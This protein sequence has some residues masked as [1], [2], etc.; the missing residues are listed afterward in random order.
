MID[1]VCLFGYNKYVTLL[2]S[3]GVSSVRPVCPALLFRWSGASVPP[4]PVAPPVAA[5]LSLLL[6]FLWPTMAPNQ[7]VMSVG[8]RSRPLPQRGTT[9]PMPT[10]SD[11]THR[12]VQGIDINCTV[13]HPGLLWGQVMSQSFSLFKGYKES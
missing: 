13:Y 10:S 4:G 1:L 9:E 2:P 11:Y 12:E 3:W 8:L 5:P 6:L 7:T